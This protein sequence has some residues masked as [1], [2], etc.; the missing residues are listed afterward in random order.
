MA[1]SLGTLRLLAH[2]YAQLPGPTWR[3]RLTPEEKM[4]I[5]TA[6]D[7]TDKLF[8]TVEQA[9]AWA[10]DPAAVSAWC[11]HQAVMTAQVARQARE[12]PREP[13]N[14]ALP[15]DGWSVRYQR[16]TDAW[17][18]ARGA[19]REVFDTEAAAIAFTHEP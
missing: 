16:A 5:A 11:D 3:L 6:P 4:V 15:A 12:R 2:H 8:D 14:R 7:G 9:L 10:N 1:E 17:E 18:A 19:Q 13:A